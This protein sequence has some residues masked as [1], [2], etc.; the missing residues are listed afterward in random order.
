MFGDGWSPVQRVGPNL[1]VR[2]GWRPV[3]V[4]VVVV[5]PVWTPGLLWPVCFDDIFDGPPADG[6]ARTDLSLQLE[7]A[8]VAQTHVAAGVDDGVHLTVE[9][10]GAFSVL[11][12]R[13]Q[14]RAGDGWGD[15]RTEG[16]AGS[17]HCKIKED[18]RTIQ[19]DQM[20]VFMLLQWKDPRSPPW[21]LSDFNYFFKIILIFFCVKTGHSLIWIYSYIF[22][23]I[24]SWNLY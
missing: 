17:R 6:A 19:K 24:Y 4:V 9:A 20:M 7:P 13:G 3:V 10:N 14:L 8:V 21:F 1:R 22:I 18:K 2:H 12:S 23:Y 16:G 5:A 15:G 11:A